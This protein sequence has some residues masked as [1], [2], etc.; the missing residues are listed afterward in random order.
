M[1]SPIPVAPGESVT[2]F[3]NSFGLIS[4]FIPEPVSLI[5]TLSSLF[6]FSALIVIFLPA[7][8]EVNFIALPNKFDITS[9]KLVRALRCA[10]VPSSRNYPHPVCVN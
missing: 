10:M 2:N 4:G 1:Y 6:F 3:E 7:S 5:H 8:F 9:L